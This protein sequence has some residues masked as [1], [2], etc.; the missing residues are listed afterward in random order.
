MSKIRLFLPKSKI[1]DIVVINDREI[2]HKTNDVL[3]LKKGERIYL[4]DGEGTEYR[5]Q[6]SETN[7]KYI[8]LKKEAVERTEG[9]PKEKITLAI[10]LLKEQRLELILQKAT[11]LGI[12]DFQLFTCERSIQGQPSSGKKERWKKIVDEATRQSDRLWLAQINEIID[13]ETL[14]KQDFNLK[15]AGS[16]AGKK[17]TSIIKEKYSKTLLA[18]GPEGDFSPNEYEKFKI[19]GFK[20]LKLSENILRVETAAIIASGLINYFLTQEI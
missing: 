2:L 16:I 3:V 18:I 1:S 7:R 11:E 12:W 14:I 13:F 15:I 17:I 19:S 5:Y 6:I 4:F 9:I 8:S 10:P 20:F